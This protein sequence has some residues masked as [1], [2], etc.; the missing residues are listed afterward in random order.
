LVA[1]DDDEIRWLV[2]TVL[3]AAGFAVEA[4]ADG[5]EALERIRRG[6][7]ELVLL[8]IRMPLLDGWGVLRRLR[9]LPQ[10]PAVI[11]LSA[12]HDCGRAMS[13]GADCLPKP[14][15]IEQLLAAC[16]KSLAA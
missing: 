1:D 5:E 12:E 8:D 10:R 9:G 11:V 4:A 7:P 2:A 16:R 15:L 14:F 6:Q 13:E 3:E